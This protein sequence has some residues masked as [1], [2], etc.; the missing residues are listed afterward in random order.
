VRRALKYTLCAGVGVGWLSVALGAQAH[1]DQS[2]RGRR[3]DTT[4]AAPTADK[5]DSAVPLTRIAE[6]RGGDPATVGRPVRVQG[7]VTYVDAAWGVLFVQDAEQGIFVQMRG[8]PIAVR[9]GDL[10]WVAD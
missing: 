7:V 10:V 9:V 3:A 5:P 8:L 6:I 1:G 4:V 2:P